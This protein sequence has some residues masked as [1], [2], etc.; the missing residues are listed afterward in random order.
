[1]L[2]VQATGKVRVKLLKA[3]STRADIPPIAGFHLQG[4]SPI[5]LRPRPD[6]SVPSVRHSK[7]PWCVQSDLDGRRVWAPNDVTNDTHD[8]VAPECLGRPKARVGAVRDPVCI[9]GLGI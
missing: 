8:S 9:D 4:A 3:G 2:T 7:G 1:M 5:S 6:L